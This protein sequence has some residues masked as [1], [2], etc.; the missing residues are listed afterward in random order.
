M[1]AINEVLEWET[2]KFV[3]CAGYLWSA[4]CGVME[5]DDLRA[6][7]QPKFRARR[8]AERAAVAATEKDPESAEKRCREDY[9]KGYDRENLRPEES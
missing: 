6:H 3:G 8:E 5:F 2:G 4:R 1:T 9:L 7:R